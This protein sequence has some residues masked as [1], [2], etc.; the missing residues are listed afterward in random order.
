MRLRNL[1]FLL[2]QNQSVILKRAFILTWVGITAVSLGFNLQHQEEKIVIIRETPS[3]SYVIPELATYGSRAKNSSAKGNSHLSSQLSYSS[4]SQTATHTQWDSLVEADSLHKVNFIKRYL[5]LVYNFDRTSIENQLSL[6]TDLMSE[7]FYRRSLRELSEFKKSIQ[8]NSEN[9]TQ[10]LEVLS[11]TKV[12]SQVFDIE[13]RIATVK[14]GKNYS[15]DYLIQM[16]ITEASKT[17]SNPW[18]LEV[19]DVKET[20]K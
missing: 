2:I 5:A 1:R 10:S 19:S 20:R 17:R 4:G 8:S 9:M 13:G 11:I 15:F 18:G 12:S 6:G 3:G 16:R 7:E 14:E